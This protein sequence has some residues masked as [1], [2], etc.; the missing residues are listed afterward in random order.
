MNHPGLGEHPRDGWLA[1][2]DQGR[3]QRLHPETLR[4]I[5]SPFSVE[6]KHLK[7][8]PDGRTMVVSKDRSITAWDIEG[9]RLLQSLHLADETISHRAAISQSGSLVTSRLSPLITST[10]YAVGAGA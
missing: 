8:L 7:L 4:P 6:G 3:T 2:S 5:G 1:V 10:G 9:N